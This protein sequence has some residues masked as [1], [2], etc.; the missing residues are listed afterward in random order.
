MPGR[1]AT[2]EGLAYACWWLR[3]DATSTGG[4]GMVTA[5]GDHDRA[6]DELVTGQRPAPPERV[7]PQVRPSRWRLADTSTVTKPRCS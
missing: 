7:E 6:V 2:L 1:A 5:V 3:D 4:A